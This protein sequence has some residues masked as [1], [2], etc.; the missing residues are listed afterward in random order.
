MR[1]DIVARLAV[2]C[3]KSPNSTAPDYG[4]RVAAYVPV[5]VCNITNLIPRAVEVAGNNIAKAASL[6]ALSRD[7]LR[8]PLKKYDLP[9]KKRSA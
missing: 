1:V 3:G 8:Y 6:L 7:T 2:R 9:R 5:A 4:Y